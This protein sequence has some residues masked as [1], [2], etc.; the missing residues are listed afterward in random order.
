[1]SY[2]LPM[3]IILNILA[4]PLYLALFILRRIQTIAL[5]VN[6]GF[7]GRRPIEIAVVGQLVGWLVLAVIIAAVIFLVLKYVLEYSLSGGGF[8]SFLWRLIVV[9]VL[10]A[11]LSGLV[12]VFA[13]LS[14]MVLNEMNYVPPAR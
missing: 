4:Q 2:N 10:Y 7:M 9:L 3:E 6:D 13:N 5:I 1:M 11:V 14:H 12:Y 8:G